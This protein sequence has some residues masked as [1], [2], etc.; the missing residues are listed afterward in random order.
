MLTDLKN[1]YITGK[2]TYR[3]LASRYG[4]PLYEIQKTA[5]CEGWVQ[6]RRDWRREHFVP[7][8]SAIIT[9]NEKD[10][11]LWE[12]SLRRTEK[13]RSVAD[14][15]LCRIE[16]R[17]DDE[18]AAFDMASIKQLA[19]VLKDIRDIQMLCS[20]VELCEQLLKLQNMEKKTSDC[21]ETAVT[22]RFEGE[23]EVLSL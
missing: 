6:A 19:A 18:D 2:T 9:K 14:K 1:E 12:S 21:E 15:L 20:P 7:M 10:A 5:K 11:V 16:G 22:V 4:I 17:V 23:T 8:P 13:L 3:D